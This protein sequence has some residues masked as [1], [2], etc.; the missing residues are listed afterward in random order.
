MKKKGRTT[1]KPKPAAKPAPASHR[2]MRA[3][4]ASR[5]RKAY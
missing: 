4:A 3:Y 2:S 5:M 1:K